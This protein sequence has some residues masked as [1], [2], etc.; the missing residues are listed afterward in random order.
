MP[1]A[2]F[3][4]GAHALILITLAWRSA[5]RL[6]ANILYRICAV[7]I[8]T[9]ANLAYTALALSLFSLLD[10]P[11]LY[12]LLSLALAAA[13]E[14]LLYSRHVT[15]ADRKPE[16]PSCRDGRFD[17]AIRIVLSGAL[18]MAALATVIISIHFVPNNWDTISYR[19]SRAF[20]YLARGNL[21]HAGNKADPRLSFY[22][23]NGVLLYLFL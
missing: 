12:F 18:A 21:L 13:I 6:T 22:P 3:L 23:F 14:I 7:Y 8:L 20:F 10:R 1:Y 16:A 19:L 15:P 5:G 17:G 2:P 11:G 9:W 4:G